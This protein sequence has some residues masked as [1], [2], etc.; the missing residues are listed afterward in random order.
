MSASP[1]VKIA[2]FRALRSLFVVAAM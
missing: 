2:D 1:R